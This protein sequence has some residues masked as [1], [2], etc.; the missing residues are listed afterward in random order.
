MVEAKNNDSTDDFSVATSLQ[1]HAEKIDK[2]FKML[3][4]CG[5]K[6][7]TLEKESKEAK[8]VRLTP[9]PSAGPSSSS[10]SVMSS[11]SSVRLETLSKDV[12]VLK[13]KMAELSMAEP[14]LDVS[15]N[16]VAKWV[17]TKFEAFMK[18]PSTR[19]RIREIVTAKVES[20]QVRLLLIFTLFHNLA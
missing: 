14:S 11:A 4:K 3:Y 18:T 13:T 17:E 5:K 9:V 20:F 2:A 7:E 10:T 15:S 12:E 1:S 19:N 16:N 8:T 6:I